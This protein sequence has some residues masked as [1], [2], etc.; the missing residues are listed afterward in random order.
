[1]TPD[2]VTNWS[3]RK[4]ADPWVTLLLSLLC[5]CVTLVYSTLSPLTQ[6]AAVE[7]AGATPSRTAVILAAAPSGWL[8]NGLLTVLTAIF[9]HSSWLHLVG[10]LAYLWVFGMPLERQPG[11]VFLGF[12]FLAGGSLANIMVALLSPES[13]VPVI[14]ASGAVSAVVGAH[15]GLFP[16]RRIGLYLPLGFYL[17]AAR[18]PSLLVIGSWF[19]LQLVYT[20]FGPI[21]GT[22]ALWTHLAGFTLGLIVAMMARAFSHL[23]I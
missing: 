14:G 12:T 23:R 17:Q 13:E 15:L 19:T 21:T 6:Q 1:V 16:S 18:V 8:Q 20:L 22:V 5:L 3:S 7:I 9:L 2:I 4:P 11:A 10:N